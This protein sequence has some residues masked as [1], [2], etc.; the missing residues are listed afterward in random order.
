MVSIKELT[1]RGFRIQYNDPHD[2]AAIIECHVLNEYHVEK[3]KRG[4]VVIDVGAGIGEFAMLASDKVGEGGKVIAI[5]PSPDDFETLQENIKENG[6][7]NVIPINSAVSNKKERLLLKFKGREFEADAE[8]LSN[9]L[10]NLDIAVNSV[11]YVKMYIEERERSVTPASIDII[12]RIDYLAIEIHDGFSSELIPYMQDLGFRFSRIERKE[13]LFNAMKEVIVHPV[14]VYR[15][16]K[17]FTGTGENPG[18]WKIS[19][20]IDISKSNELVVGLFCKSQT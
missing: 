2:I 8:T 5:E 19:S 18:L 13:Y 16:W 14:G 3:I 7:S 15:M 17:A 4:S 20:G 11:N 9:I 10:S 1:F 6:C 12:R